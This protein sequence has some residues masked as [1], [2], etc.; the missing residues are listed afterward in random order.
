MVILKPLRTKSIRLKRC[1]EKL[2]Y[3][4]IFGEIAA[5]IFEGIFEIQISAYI[6]FKY[7]QGYELTLPFFVSCLIILLCFVI[8]PASL[9]WLMKLDEEKVGQ[10][11]TLRVMQISVDR[12]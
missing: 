12:S 9:I 8:I 11:N 5:I 7:S 1:Y 2:Y 6:T 10:L 3:I 4:L